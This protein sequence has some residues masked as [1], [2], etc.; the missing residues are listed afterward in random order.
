MSRLFQDELNYLRDVGR[1][2]AQINPKLARYLSESSTDPDVERLM[3]GFAFLTSRVRAKIEDEMPEFTH[4]VISLVWPNFLRAFPS[5]TMMKLS[6]ID[7]SITERQIVPKGTEIQSDP[8]NGITC[9]FMTTTD[10]AVYPLEIDGLRLERSRDNARIRISLRTLSGLPLG[11]IGLRDLRLNFTGDSSTCQTLHLWAGRY[12]HDIKV[13]FGEDD[14]HAL[15]PEKHMAAIGMSADEAILPQPRTAFEGHR[16]LQEFFVFPEKFF[17]YDLLQLGDV[18]RGRSESEFEIEL[19]FQ[20]PLPVDVRLRP[21]AIQL[22]CAPAVNLFATSAEPLLIDHR[23]TAYPIRPQLQEAGDIEIFSIDRIAS[24]FTSGQAGRISSSRVYPSFESFDHEI[25]R[26]G[27][28]TQIYYRQRARE[29]LG[30]RGFRY[31]VS[32]VHHDTREIAPAEEALSVDLT[33]FNRDVCAELA[34]G[35]VRTAPK[36][37]P[38]FVQYA[39]ITRPTSPVYPPLDGTLDWSLISSLSLNYTSLLDRDAIAAILSTY[40]YRSLYDR[41]AERAARQRLAGIQTLVTQ[42]ID[43]LFKGMPVRGLKSRMTMKESCFQ[44]EGE[45]YLFASILAEFFALYATVNSFHQLEV[46]GEE[47]GEIYTWQPRIGRQPLI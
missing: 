4:S 40:D 8:V 37:A 44:T 10:C 6:P 19:E 36:S 3:E 29:A 24:H 2:F 38:T 14:A 13:I 28:E 46:R 5:T 27:E 25:G 1:E 11:Q 15:R 21:D 23:K 12:L 18:F 35:S 22:Y 43:R 32:F 41:Q 42:P 33:C 45:M 39:N 31:E 47:H 30:H 16:L 7:R 17:G 34:V 26:D 9:R 20:R